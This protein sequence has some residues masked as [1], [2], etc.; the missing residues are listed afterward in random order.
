M[1]LGFHK[2]PQDFFIWG[3]FSV[4]KLTWLLGDSGVVCVCI[5][6]RYYQTDTFGKTVMTA[7]HL[8]LCAPSPKFTRCLLYKAHVSGSL[9]LQPFQFSHISFLGVSIR[10]SPSKCH[11]SFMVTIQLFISSTGPQK[12]CS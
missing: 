6:W 12:R 11:P 10:L 2:T 9:R 4:N 3:Y 7:L 1:L 5:T 8:L